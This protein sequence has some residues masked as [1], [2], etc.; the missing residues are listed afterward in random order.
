MPR[1]ATTDTDA[2]T[3]INATAAD[4]HRRMADSS[5]NANNCCQ[6]QLEEEEDCAA[7]LLQ[8]EDTRTDVTVYYDDH[9]ANVIR[10]CVE[11]WAK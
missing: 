9:M 10:T 1:A 11:Q 5:R 6:S 3:D 8:V 2:A 7:L 4:C